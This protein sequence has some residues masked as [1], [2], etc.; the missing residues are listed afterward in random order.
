MVKPDRRKASILY[1]LLVL[2]W[3]RRSRLFPAVKILQKFR[4]WKDLGFRSQK[5]IRVRKD[6]EVLK[7]GQVAKRRFSLQKIQAKEALVR[8]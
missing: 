2:D 6:K 4:R 1:G 7:D 5:N 8:L 3:I